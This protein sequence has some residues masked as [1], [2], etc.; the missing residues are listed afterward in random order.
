MQYPGRILMIRKKIPNVIMKKYR[1]LN[2]VSNKKKLLFFNNGNEYSNLEEI[3]LLYN[4]YISKFNTSIEKHNKPLL[5][6]KRKQI[7]KKKKELLKDT[8]NYGKEIVFFSIQVRVY[9]VFLY[10]Y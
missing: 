1:Y 10:Q 9:Y 5:E 2:T 6:L 7:Y 4:E 3:R 8:K